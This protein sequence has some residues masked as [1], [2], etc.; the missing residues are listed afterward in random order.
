M[1][2][3]SQDLLVNILDAWMREEVLWIYLPG[4]AGVVVPWVIAMSSRALV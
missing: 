2:R 1:R 3:R 4:L